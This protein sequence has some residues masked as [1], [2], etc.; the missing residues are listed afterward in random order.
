M[1][2][3]ALFQSYANTNDF[4]FI[5]TDGSMANWQE[6]KNHN[7]GWFNILSSLKITPLRDEFMF[8]SENTVICTWQGRFDMTLKSGAEVMIN[9]FGITFV[10]IKSDAGWKVLYQHS[11]A[12]PPVQKL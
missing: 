4:L 8:P 12:L 3:E 6:A 5:G 11:S 2:A 1:D 7:A 10:F 9:P